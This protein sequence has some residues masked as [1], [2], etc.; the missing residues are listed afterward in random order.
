MLD[1]LDLPF[2]AVQG[3]SLLPEFAG[4]RLPDRTLL[5]DAVAYGRDKR[6]T[7]DGRYKLIV[8]DG[9]PTV[10][11]D[12]IED[13][14]ERHD[15]SRRDAGRTARAVAPLDSLYADAVGRGLA[16][17]GAAVEDGVRPDERHVETLR[18][19]GYVR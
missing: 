9:G 13:P 3:V 2:A 10:L 8:C 18:A 6:A 7:V 19:L 16:I 1:Y 5:L 12:L 11:F 14:A 4:A 17:R 15:L